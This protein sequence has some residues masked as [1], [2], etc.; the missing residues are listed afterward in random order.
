[1]DLAEA[2]NGMTTAEEDVVDFEALPRLGRALQVDDIVA[3]KIFEPNEKWEPSTSDWKKARVCEIDGNEA[4]LEILN[5]PS[6][7]S[8][9]DTDLNSFYRKVMKEEGRENIDLVQIPEMLDVRLFPKVD[10]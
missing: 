10:G 7:E 6:I 1:M 3:Y 8:D 2:S 5:R 4:S 9:D